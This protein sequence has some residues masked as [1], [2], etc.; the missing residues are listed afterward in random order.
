MNG[1]Y[2]EKGSEFEPSLEF[3]LKDIDLGEVR[4]LA[5]SDAYG[6]PETGA[7]QSVGECCGCCTTF[8]PSH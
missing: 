8:T 5:E 3:D 2:R 7:S 4:V 6:L 1:T